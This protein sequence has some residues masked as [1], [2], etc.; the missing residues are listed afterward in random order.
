M[1]TSIPDTSDIVEWKLPS[2]RKVGMACLITTETAL[3]CIFVVAYIYN[4]DKSF[5][6][7]YPLDILT[8]PW[9]ASFFLLSSSVTIYFAEVAFHKDNIGV[10]RFWWGITILFGAIF[11]AFTAYEWYEFI[12]HHGLTI[13][14][15]LFGATFYSL[16][17]LHASHVIVGLG[18]LTTVFVFSLL[19]KV[20][21]AA[22]EERLMM[23]SWYWHFVDAIWII[24]FTV[25]YVIGLGKL[26]Q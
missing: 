25:V 17:G 24:V 15:N 23:I 20:D 10:F 2:K 9:L 13:S 22:H 18:L 26:H 7:P 11:L 16:V 6:G 19:G 4:I 8:K 5:I 3:F 21:K 12:Y 14:T 1:Q